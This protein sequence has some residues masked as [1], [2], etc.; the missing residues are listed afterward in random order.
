MKKTILFFFLA[1]AGHNLY[2]QN[3]LDAVYS[4]T[5]ANNTLLKGI[6]IDATTYQRVD[7]VLIIVTGS[8]GSAREFYSD[9]A[10]N[11]T[12]LTQLSEYKI[13]LKKGNYINEE[14]EIEIKHQ[15]DTLERIY[16]LERE[17][18]YFY[19]EVNNTVLTW[20]KD[21]A[22]IFVNTEGEYQPDMKQKNGLLCEV[23]VLTI[24]DTLINCITKKD[25]F[26]K[27][28]DTEKGIKTEIVGT[29]SVTL[30][31]SV[32]VEEEN[33]PGNF[34]TEY[35][36][37]VNVKTVNNLSV[38]FEPPQRGKYAYA[39]IKEAYFFPKSRKWYLY[40]TYSSRFESIEHSGQ[41]FY[42]GWYLAE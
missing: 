32:Q 18:F 7:S 41:L 11:F 21:T 36:Y 40:A 29:V 13:Y 25:F 4:L 3:I 19:S 5:A 16:Y 39:H 20:D 33:Y 10:G 38:S 26:S 14:H 23:E 22:G 1:V 9:A 15:P 2:A 27:Y 42:E 37:R 30:L 24:G 8:D 35:T 6:V 31:D 28:T 34:Y 17:K 12:F